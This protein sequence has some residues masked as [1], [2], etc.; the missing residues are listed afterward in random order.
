MV[1]DV[2]LAYFGPET[3]MPLASA[4]AAVAGAA[5]FVGRGTVHW[6]KTTFNKILGRSEPEAGP[7]PGSTPEPEGETVSDGGGEEATI[8]DGE[9]GRPTS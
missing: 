7:G 8:A 9:A 4:L 6:V 3:T 5:M 2:C 1:L